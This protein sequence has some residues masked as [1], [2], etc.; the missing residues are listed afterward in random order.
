MKV[1]NVSG[2]SRFAVPY[3][4]SSWLDYWEKQI[5]TKKHTY[6]AKVCSNSDLVGAHVQMANSNDK[7]WYITPLCK[8]CNQRTNELDV[9]WNLVPVPSNLLKFIPVG[10]SCGNQQG[11]TT[12]IN[13]INK[14]CLQIV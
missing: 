4:F 8:A 13:N 9:F 10:S 1:K 6:G 2:S 7:R 12:T 5:G 3:G 11:I 14:V